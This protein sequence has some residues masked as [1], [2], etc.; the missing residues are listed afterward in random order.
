MELTA[1]IHTVSIIFEGMIDA[2]E[3][4]RIRDCIQSSYFKNTGKTSCKINVNRLYGDIYKYSEF[5]TALDTITASAGIKEFNI[6]RVDVRLDSYNREDYIKYVKLNRMILSLLG[7]AYTTPSN[8]KSMDLFTN[9][10]LSLSV[11]NDYFQVEYYDKYHQSRGKDQAKSRLELRSLKKRFGIEELRNKFQEE[12]NRRWQKAEECFDEMQMKYNQAMEQ[13]YK[14]DQV[15]F[16]RKFT[17]VNNF[18]T[19]YQECIFTKKQMLDLLSR[20]TE[21]KNP[22]NKEKNYRQKYKIKYYTFQDVAMTIQNIKET[23]TQ[24]FE[25]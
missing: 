4:G 19:Q 11:R 9:Q 12:W 10:P 1:S 15:T 24:F 21:V 8:Y 18:L 17:S 14:Q 5:R 25:N 22:Q 6:S 3:E 7:T 13:V 23:V 2:V 16:P 20:F